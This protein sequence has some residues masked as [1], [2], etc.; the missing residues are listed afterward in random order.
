MPMMKAV[1]KDGTEVH[2]G[3][4]RVKSNENGTER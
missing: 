3:K 1:E 4:P 2:H